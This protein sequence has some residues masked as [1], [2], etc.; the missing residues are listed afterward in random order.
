V[1]WWPLSVRPSVP[2]LIRNNFAIGRA[3]NW[4]EGRSWHGWTVTQFTC[5]KVK[6]QGHQADQRRDR[7]SA[8]SLDWEGL[9]TSEL[10]SGWSMMSRITDMSGDP[11]PSWKFCVTVQVTTCRG[12]GHI[13]AAP[14]FIILDN[15]W[16]ELCIRNSL[17][18]CLW[19]V[20]KEIVSQWYMHQGRSGYIY[21]NKNGS[22]HKSLFW[23]TPSSWRDRPQIAAS[24]NSTKLR[25]IQ[26]MYWWL[27][28]MIIMI[29]VVLVNFR[30]LISD[31]RS[32]RTVWPSS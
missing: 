19:T 26:K 5:Q 16:R 24:L 2:W 6:D 23:A 8:V 30:H 3:E 4:Q 1:H 17:F 10:V 12:Q 32:L 18:V 13:V 15:A 14:Q 27:L 31:Y 22:V 28:L 9:R 29:I 21:T 7:K 20:L 11:P 25:F